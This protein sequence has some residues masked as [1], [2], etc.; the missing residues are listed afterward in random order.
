LSEEELVYV[1]KFQFTVPDP[2]IACVFEL[3]TSEVYILSVVLTLTA[4][5]EPDPNWQLFTFDVVAPPCVKHVV[6]VAVAKD[7]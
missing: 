5:A 6:F 3:L 2:V 4:E 7:V 1:V